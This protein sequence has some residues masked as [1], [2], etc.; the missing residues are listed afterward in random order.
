[1]E[2]VF[3][4]KYDGWLVNWFYLMNNFIYLFFKSFYGIYFMFSFGV[5]LFESFGVL[6]NLFFIFI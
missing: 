6:L 4:G 2:S 5:S 3:V 1:M